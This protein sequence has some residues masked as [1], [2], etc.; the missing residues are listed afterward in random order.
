[1]GFFGLF[2]GS[3]GHVSPQK[4]S[5][6][7]GGPSIRQNGGDYWESHKRSSGDWLPKAEYERQTGRPGKK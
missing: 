2:S 4:I 1:M 7:Q 6:D 3:K 5:R